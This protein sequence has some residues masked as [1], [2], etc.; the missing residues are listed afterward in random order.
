MLS[1]LFLPGVAALLNTGTPIADRLAL[2][3]ELQTLLPPG[4]PPR[5]LAGRAFEIVDTL[6]N[7][8][9]VPAT[10]GFLTLGIGGA[11]SLA[12]S[13]D[14]PE[15]EDAAT[16][17]AAPPAVALLAVR[18]TLDFST[19]RAYNV[20][21]FSI[22]EGIAGEL[23]GALELDAICAQ[24]AERADTL[25]FVTTERRLKIPRAPSCEVPAMM[26]ALHAQ[27]SHDFLA[28]EGVRLGLQTTYLD[29]QLR[30]TRCTTRELAGSCAV[31]WRLPQEEDEEEGGDGA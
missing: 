2:R 23:S 10:P 26:E 22:D 12:G 17:S 24:N 5:A 30:I 18:Q 27:L 6:E 29:E 11:W 16:S 15:R 8:E 9:N 19:E 25:N 13:Q 14:A 31:H 1:L 3:A 20:V 4:Q 28:D 7:L 21:E